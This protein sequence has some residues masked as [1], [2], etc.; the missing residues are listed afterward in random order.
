MSTILCIF[1]DLASSLDARACTCRYTG[2]RPRIGFDK[3]EITKIAMSIE[4]YG[5]SIKP[6]KDACSINAK[7]PVTNSSLESFKRIAKEINLDGAVKRSL[8][9]ALAEDMP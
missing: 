1:D 4:T 6:Y 8:K 5:E 2:V 3:E 9:E 7:N